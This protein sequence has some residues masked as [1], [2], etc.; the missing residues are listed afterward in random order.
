LSDFRSPL[1][2]DANA[3][4]VALVTGG[5]TGIG[6]AIAEALAAS[7]AKLALC[8][9]RP[10]PLL[11]AKAAIEAA[12]GACFT[13]ACDVR[14]PDQVDAMLDAV[15]EHYGR[16]D[17]VV[18]NAGGQFRADAENISLKGFRAVHRLALDATWDVTSKAAARF[19]IPQRSGVVLFISFSP[20][21][22]VGYAHATAARVAVENLAASLGSEW[23][24]YGIRTVALGVG[25]VLTEG[26]LDAYG[27][28]VVRAWERSVPLGRLG[29]PDDIA[30]LAAF[31]ASP[32]ASWITATTVKVDGG[33]S[34]WG[35][36]EEPP[37]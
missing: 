20:H 5:G 9:R 26:A 36:G 2:E 33:Q 31:L 30:Q 13:T 3:G 15:G 19:L 18:N 14:E 7:G 22:Q 16:L 12:G 34:A 6:R 35:A 1:V 25:Q 23:A 4:K 10:E 28:D 21:V 32:A 11:E 24:R 8:G 27:E 17:I 37:R 29:R